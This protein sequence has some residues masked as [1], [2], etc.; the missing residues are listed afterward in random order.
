MPDPAPLTDVDLDRLEALAAAATPG[1]LASQWGNTHPYPHRVWA[2]SGTIAQCHSLTDADFFAA[3]REAVPALLAEV[4]RLCA[5]A[6]WDRRTPGLPPIP[7]TQGRYDAVC[8]QRAELEAENTRL[9]EALAPFARGAA[10]YA[11]STAEDEYMAG[12]VGV[13]V[14]DCRRAREALAAKG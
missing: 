13:T 2:P 1:P 12:P 7:V 5:D 9:R 4:R 8:Q 10:V 14:G 6:P 3:A 11:I